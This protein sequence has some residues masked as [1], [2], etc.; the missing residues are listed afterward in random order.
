MNAAP[1]AKLEARAGRAIVARCANG[2]LVPEGGVALPV[3]FSR[4]LITAALGQAGM[5][6][7]EVQGSVLAEHLTEDV[8]RGTRVAVFHD[9][10]QQILAGEYVVRHRE[11]DLETGMARFDLEL[12]PA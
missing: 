9:D 1:F 4:P 5:Q 3:V 6:T 12:A 11:D 10:Q 2:Y 8:Q 7:R